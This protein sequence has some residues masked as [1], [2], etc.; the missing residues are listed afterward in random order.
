MSAARGDRIGAIALRIWLALGLLFLFAPIA[1]AVAWSFNAGV[2]GRQTA[3]FT[4]VSVQGYADASVDGSLRDAAL[5]SVTIALWVTAIA[6]LLGTAL[7]WSLVRHPSRAVRRALGALVVALL[8]VPETVLGVTL[9]LGYTVTHLPLG[10][11]SLIAAHTPPCISIVAFL[12]RVRLSTLDPL[13]EDAAADLGATGP[14]AFRLVVLPQL[15]PA[16][17]ASALLAYVFSFDNVVISSFLSTAQ[18]STLPV[19]LYGA[20][21]YGPTPAVYAA[22]SVLFAGTVLAVV[23]AVVLLRSILRRPRI[24]GAPA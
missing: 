10:V 15:G 17:A 19:Y 14:A 12:V 16:V 6:L 1:I 20:L 11:A 5:T 9:L 4:G 13:L 24:T 22:S 3:A 8:I 21:Q 7:G 23:I 18:V 2:N